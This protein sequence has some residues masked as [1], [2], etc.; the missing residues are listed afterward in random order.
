MAAEA[1]AGAADD[2][3]AGSR[4]NAAGRVEVAAGG[5]ATAVRRAASSPAVLL[6]PSL[7]LALGAL[8]LALHERPRLPAY[9]QRIFQ[10]L[11][12]RNEPDGALLLLALVLLA[13][14]VARLL[15]TK[16][17]ALPAWLAS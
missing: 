15:G 7:L 5:A 13:P 17:L 12:A 8:M 14:I 11:F 4:E 10:L 9:R 6:L 3:A 1:G 2:A 16:W